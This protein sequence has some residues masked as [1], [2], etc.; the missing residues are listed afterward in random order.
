MNTTTRTYCRTMQEAFGPYTSNVIE[1][2]A[3]RDVG[4][5]AIWWGCIA[6]I[7][8]LTALLLTA[9]A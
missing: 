2:P 4:Y 3:E 9:G 6:V 8:V 1:E 5:G 7:A